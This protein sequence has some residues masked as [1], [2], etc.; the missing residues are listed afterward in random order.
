MTSNCCLR[1]RWRAHW[2]SKAGGGGG[3]GGGQVVVL[4]PPAPAHP[5]DRVVPVAT[6]VLEVEKTATGVEQPPAH[7]SAR[8]MHVP[9]P[10]QYKHTH[11]LV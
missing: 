8:Y 5:N 10:P 1:N 4:N 7:I 6:H 2:L 3:G 11:S 9:P